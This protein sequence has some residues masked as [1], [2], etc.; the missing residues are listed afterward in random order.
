[1][2][3]RVARI[4]AVASFLHRAPSAEVADRCA[5]DVADQL[6]VELGALGLGE[7]EQD[8]AVGAFFHEVGEMLSDMQAAEPSSAEIVSLR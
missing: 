7:A 6:F 2:A 8:E 4:R 5:G 1:M 3:R